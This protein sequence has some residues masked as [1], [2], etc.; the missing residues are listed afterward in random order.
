M[1]IPTIYADRDNPFTLTLKQNNVA[2]I[3]AVMNTFT[4]YEIKFQGE[5][6]DSVTYP[7]AFEISNANATV[8]IKPEEFDLSPTNRVGEDCVFLVYD[9]SDYDD[10]LVWDIFKLVVSDAAEVA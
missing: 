3:E 4:K 1:A 6:Y 8:T 7:N 10:G 5:Y 9:A 2:V